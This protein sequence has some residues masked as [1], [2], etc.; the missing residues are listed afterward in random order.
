MSIWMQPSSFL[1]WNLKIYYLE[2]VWTN[3]TKQRYFFKKRD[4]NPTST[5][6]LT[7]IPHSFIQ[8]QE[9][10][11]T[12]QGHSGSGTYLRNTAQVCGN[13]PYT[14]HHIIPHIHTS[15]KFGLPNLFLVFGWWKEARNPKGYP[16]RYPENIRNSAQ[17]GTQAQD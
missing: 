9:L 8:L 13:T 4:T 10:F 6:T 15:G 1:K 5:P 16:Y 12:T 11:Y 3:L 14:S 7:F 2:N 17:R